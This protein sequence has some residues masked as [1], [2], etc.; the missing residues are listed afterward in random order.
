MSNKFAAVIM[1]AG[2]STRMKSALPK[3]AHTICGKAMTRHI[4]DACIAA[5]IKDVVVVVGYEAEKVK[6]AIGEDISYAYQFEQLGTGHAC[7]QAM[8]S[9]AQDITDVVVLPGDAPLITSETLADLINTHA[10]TGNAAT[11]LTAVLDD[12]T[13]YGRIVRDDNGSVMCITEA[14]DADAKTLAIGEINTSIY[15][16]HK[17]L[18]AEKLAMLRNNNAQGEYYLTDV[19]GMLGNTGPASASGYRSNNTGPASASGYRSNGKVGAVIADNAIDVMGIN[20]RVELAASAAEMR[21]RINKTHMLAGVTI[22][23]PAS[24][25]IDCDVLIGKDTIIHPCTVIERGSNIGANCE[26]G[27]FVRL[28][29]V[30]MADGTKE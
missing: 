1:A 23:D 10:S 25:Y 22:I 16:F 18:L 28:R 4:V 26:V 30:T 19:I 20:N 29:N 11:L 14:K 21:R 3:G 7:L 15:C 27:P 2:K 8:P 6:A 12:A 24:A 9:I 13:H 17:A 5:G